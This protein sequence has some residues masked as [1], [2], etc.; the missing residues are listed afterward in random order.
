[1]ER[2]TSINCEEFVRMGLNPSRKT[3]G[4]NAEG[5]NFWASK[6][7][8]KDLKQIDSIFQR[9]ADKDSPDVIGPETIERLCMDLK[10]EIMDVKLLMLAWK[11]RAA[12][13]GYFTL[14]EW[15][16]GL[17]SLKVNTIDKLKNSLPALE[18]EVMRSQSFWDFYTYSF[19]YC[20]TDGQKYLDIESVCELLKLVLG[21]RNPAQVESLIEFLKNQE[22]CKAIILDQ[23]QC[24]LSFFD[25]INY[26]SFDN[27][28]S[29]DAWPLLLDDYVEWAQKRPS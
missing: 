14:E 23:W 1:M 2:Y 13:Q 29:S 5:H 10:I 24:F 12:R 4:G 6:G 26:P 19:Q 11:M 25:K 15:H 9:Y 3:G 8:D 7:A 20:L 16:R 18:Q 28:D 22:D 21:N 17:Q 27:Y